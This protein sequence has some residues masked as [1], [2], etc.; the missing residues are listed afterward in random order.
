MTKNDETI[1]QILPEQCHDDALPK[2]RPF[3]LT[4]SKFGNRKR[5]LIEW[6]ENR[7]VSLPSV[8]HLQPLLIL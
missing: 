7:P 6:Q 4:D 8:N 2:F 5:D 3:R 1:S